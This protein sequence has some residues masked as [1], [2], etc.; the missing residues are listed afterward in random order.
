MGSETC[1]KKNRH[2]NIYVFGT[3]EVWF[4]RRPHYG[5]TSI[6]WEAGEKGKFHLP[7][8]CET[9]DG[10][11]V[12]RMTLAE[13]EAFLSDNALSFAP[14]RIPALYPRQ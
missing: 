5:M 4:T 6:Y 1:L 7:P 12:P 14:L 10:A 2:P 11:L 8:G 9:E 3:V 13:V